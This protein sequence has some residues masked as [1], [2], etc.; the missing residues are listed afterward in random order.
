MIE[1]EICSFKVH[2]ASQTKF[3][4]DIQVKMAEDLEEIRK[5]RLYK[6]WKK[7][8]SAIACLRLC[9]R[10]Y[11]KPNQLYRLVL[12]RHPGRKELVNEKKTLCRKYL[13]NRREST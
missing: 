10:T 4:T 6:R 1:R 8:S 11:K 13:V 5:T 2:F 9:R 12:Y 3:A 7:S